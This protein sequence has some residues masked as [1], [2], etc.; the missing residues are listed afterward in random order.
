[1]TTASKKQ[2]F[3]EGD[4]VVYHPVGGAMQTTTGVIKRVITEEEEVGT[5]HTTMHASEAEPRYVIENEH[6]RKETAY[7][8]ENIVEK[9]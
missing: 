8:R 4:R 3:K 1:M 7:K 9:A 5:R 6:T 2:D